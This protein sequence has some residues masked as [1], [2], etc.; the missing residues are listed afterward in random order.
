MTR[1]ALV[2]ACVA[3]AAALAGGTILA[4]PARSEQGVYAKR[5]AGTMFCALALIL[6]VFA[7]GLERIAAS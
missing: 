2:M 1:A 4:R 6:A 3:A 7:W 5:I